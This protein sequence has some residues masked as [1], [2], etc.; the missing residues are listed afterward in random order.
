MSVGVDGDGLSQTLPRSP[1]VQC[2]WKRQV[3][4]I[5]FSLFFAFGFVVRR[6]FA[7]GLEQPCISPCHL[8]SVGLF[9]LFSSAT[10]EGKKPLAGGWPASDRGI[11]TQAFGQRQHALNPNAFLLVAP[12][13]KVEAAKGSTLARQARIPGGRVGSVHDH[14]SQTNSDISRGTV[15]NVAAVIAQ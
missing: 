12:R 14:F 13:T 15:R 5:A 8:P 9:L 11:T 7:M 6:L 1:H 10:A 2:Q 4:V 3:N